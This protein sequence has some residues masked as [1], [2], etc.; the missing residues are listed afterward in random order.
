MKMDRA[1]MESLYLF[2]PT[3]KCLRTSI[4]PAFILGGFTVTESQKNKTN[5]LE[6]STN[7]TGV[8]FVK[9]AWDFCE[10][11][12]IY[13]I[14]CCDDF[15]IVLYKN[16][17]GYMSIVQQYVSFNSPCSVILNENHLTVYTTLTL[18]IRV[19]AYSKS[20]SSVELSVSLSISRMPFARTVSKKRG[21][22]DRC[23]H[24]L[25]RVP[26]T[27]RNIITTFTLLHLHS[28]HLNYQPFPASFFQWKYWCAPRSQPSVKLWWTV[29]KLV[30]Q[31]NRTAEYDSNLARF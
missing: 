22:I 27:C 8:I 17:P 29:L 2:K 6:I 10:F 1:Y 11:F 3:K 25:I 16:F 24:A 5:F 13:L 28:L 31:S 30:L 23:A 4:S 20:S 21:N 26:C 7:V 19:I 14:I 12:V 9:T 18:L 15:V